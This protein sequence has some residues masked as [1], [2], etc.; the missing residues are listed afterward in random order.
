[1]RGPAVT[2]FAETAALYAMLNEDTEEAERIV[3]D[4]LPNERREFADQ[5]DKLRSMLIDR[6]GNDRGDGP[7]YI[8]DVLAGKY[9]GP[10][11]S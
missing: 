6:F 7:S 1:M 9:T 5:L 10:R 11:P 3:S 2:T 8:D 4:M